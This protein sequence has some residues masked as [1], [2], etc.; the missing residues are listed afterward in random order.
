AGGWGLET[1]EDE[2]AA[3]VLA[4]AM[5][6]AFL[7]RNLDAARKL[8]EEAHRRSPSEEF[9]NLLGVWAGDEA[10]NIAWQTEALA[11]RPHYAVAY[12]DRGLAKGKSGDGAGALADYTKALE[13]DPRFL[14][15]RYN[16]ARLYLGS[17]RE[18]RKALEDFAQMLKMN[19]KIPSV[20]AG[21]AEARAQMGD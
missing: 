1:M 8:L 11:I 3:E 13:I 15:A 10:A 5:A 12:F 16:R 4:R 19:T 21:R 20:Y 18:P 6:M 7:D 17:L 9:C 14:P 2:K